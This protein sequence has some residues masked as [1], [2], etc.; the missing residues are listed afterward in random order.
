[1]GTDKALP[2]SYTLTLALSLEHARR[3]TGTLLE[4]VRGEQPTVPPCHLPILSIAPTFSQG[5]PAVAEYLSACNKNKL[6]WSCPPC[7]T[8]FTWHYYYYY[9]YHPLRPNPSFSF[10]Y[11]PTPFS[12]SACSGLLCPVSNLLF[13]V[14]L[15]SIF[16]LVGISFLFFFL[17]FL[18]FSFFFLFHFI[19]FLFFI[20]FIFWCLFSHLLP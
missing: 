7:E 6:F 9:Y 3:L 13:L 1:M 11:R 20:F 19:Y 12:H 16:T 18:F 15:V 10:F 14:D 17:L 4:T 5:I 8:W 2:P